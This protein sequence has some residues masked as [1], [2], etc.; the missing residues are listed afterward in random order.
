MNEPRPV[1]KLTPDIVAEQLDKLKRLFP[2]AIT[3]GEGG[4]RVDFDRLRAT[5]GDLDALAGDD[6][7]TFTWAGKQ[8]AFR[9]IQ[10]PSAASLQ[11]VPEESVN[12]D[13]TKHIF[14]EGENLEVLKLLY[15]SYVGKVKMIYID[16]PYN[17][18]NDFIYRDDYREPL[19]AYLE[20]TGQIDAAG[21]VLTSNPETRG[22]FHSD[23]LT[24][25]YPRLF[26]A[27]QLLR[28]DG[29]IFVSIDDN[30]VYHLR[31]LMNEIFGE[32]N[33]IAQ[34]VWE[35]GRKND[36]KLFSVGHEYMLVFA[37]SMDFLRLLETVWREPKPGAQE[38]WEKYLLLRKAF[39][40]NDEAIESAL[41]DWYAQLPSEHPSKALS[42][43]RHVDQYGPWR[44]RDISWPGGG[45]PRYDVIHPLT[46]KPCKIP[47]SG[48]R[49]ATPEAM[50]R[51]IE[52]GLVV[53]RDDHNDPPFRKAHLRPVS[54]ELDDNGEEETEDDSEN[55]GVGLQVMP[56]VI[57]KQSQVAVKHLRHLMGAKVFDNPKDHEV[58]ARLIRYVTLPDS[59]PIVLD[60]FAGSASTAEAVLRMNR[61]D[62]STSRFILV[63]IPEPISESSPARSAGYDNIAE[64]A[65]ERVRRVI[66]ELQAEKEGKLNFRPDEDLGLRAFR[67]APSTFR[68]WTPPDQASAETLE[69][70]LS[71]FDEGLNDSAAPL[72]VVYEVL[73]KE[74]YSLNSTIA[75]L[76]AG[77]NTIY[78]ITDEGF[79]AP[80][81]KGLASE[82]GTPQ[83]R[84]GPLS[85]S[86]DAEPPSFYLCLDDAI[87]TE[88]LD[89]LPLDDE[90]VFICQDA[91][92]DDS[93]KVNLALQCVLK[94]I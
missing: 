85:S 89:A 86:A 83:D 92:L 82:E 2:E 59:E 10:T 44:D 67:L 28:E 75:T 91:A 41:Q 84:T 79:A 21:N 5:L 56:S 32:E 54:D 69:Q 74:G 14:I 48:W 61:E 66:D 16:P 70:Q 64:I 7:Y 47:A 33:F 9:A 34:L 57:Y 3:E 26:L 90:T 43:Y 39:G 12:W 36:A 6:A 45:G 1:A 30:E 4:P 31:L 20:K 58:L 80:E 13:T 60:F 42:R 11:P 27:R 81:L 53:F 73:L 93:Q 8:E 71:F 63:Q 24:M 88:A 72:H 62:S 46:G 65:R 25:M 18:G 49:F 78:R 17:T 55:V 15:K 40:E 22:R 77:A 19:Q 37:R 52:L 87:A 68:R 35:K 29:V 50:Q 23:W 76:T 94:T 51:Q 38:I